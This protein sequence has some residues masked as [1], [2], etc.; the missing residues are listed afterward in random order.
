MFS[1]SLGG[2]GHACILLKTQHCGQTQASL[3]QTCDFNNSICY[4]HLLE[5]TNGLFGWSKFLLWLSIIVWMWSDLRGLR[6][7]STW[8][9]VGGAVWEECGAFKKVEP[10]CRKWVTGVVLKVFQPGPISHSF[11]ASWRLVQCDHPASDLQPC[12]PCRDGQYPPKAESHNEP[13]LLQCLLS[14]ILSQQG[15]TNTPSMCWGCFSKWWNI[16]SFPS[17][18]SEH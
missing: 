8:F 12:L 6:Y 17:D 5:S 13:L 9:P 2:R 18:G 16:F 3:R 7:L 11:S 1:F 4:Y 10:Y 14:S 15:V